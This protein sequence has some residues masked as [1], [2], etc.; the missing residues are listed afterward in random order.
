MV[1]TSYSHGAAIPYEVIARYLEQLDLRLPESTPQPLPANFGDP[2]RYKALICRELSRINLEGFRIKGEIQSES[3]DMLWVPAKTHMNNSDSRER[4]PSEILLSEA[5]NRNRCLAVLGEAGSGKT[6]FLKRIGYALAR[7]DRDR[8]TLQLRSKGM[9]FWVPLKE[10][11]NVIEANVKKGGLYPSEAK[12]IRWIALY[13]ASRDDASQSGLSCEY[14]DHQLRRP[15][16]DATL[17]LDGFDEVSAARRHELKLL[18]EKAAADFGCGI[19]ISTRPEAAKQRQGTDTPSSHIFAGVPQ[20][21]ILPLDNPGVEQFITVWANTFSQNAGDAKEQAERL[22][23]AV[24]RPGIRHMARNSLM[25]TAMAVLTSN[26]QELPAERAALFD[27]IVDW[28]VK[29]RSK[30]QPE[31]ANDLRRNLA[32]LAL[33]MIDSPRP[34]NTRFPWARRRDCSPK[35][36]SPSRRGCRKTKR[37]TIWKPPSEPLA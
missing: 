19:V 24:K 21:S 32:D 15:D 13:L 11:E 28:L 9:P 37:M 17:L 6:T 5:V 3:I 10:L 12:D 27:E 30:D 7:A 25:L 29:S 34:T 8:E 4:G 33:K 2:L 22:R 36:S 31:R 18:I 1:D 35:T 20:V 16:A 14:F 26:R 23:T